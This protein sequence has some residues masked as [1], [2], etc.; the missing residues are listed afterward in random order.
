MVKGM[1]SLGIISFACIFLTI[2]TSY[3]H[4]SS[5]RL[6][7]GSRLT[8]G[9]IGLSVDM[10]PVFS[11]FAPLALEAWRR[12][13]IEPVF[14]LIGNRTS[15]SASTQSQVVIDY[16]RQHQAHIAHVNPAT[17]SRPLSSAF[18]STVGRLFVPNLLALDDVLMM[19]DIDVL[20]LK[21][22]YFKSVVKTLGTN[23]KMKMY[24]DKPVD[25][26][27]PRFSMCYIAGQ[28]RNWLELVPQANDVH[29]FLEVILSPALIHDI[30]L[31]NQEPNLAPSMNF[32]EQYLGYRIKN[33]DCYPDCTSVGDKS[34]ARDYKTL[35][36]GPPGPDYTWGKTLQ[37][38]GKEMLEYLS[39]QIEG[40][41]GEGS[42]SL[43]E[44]AKNP[45]GTLFS[46]IRLYWESEP[47]NRVMDYSKTFFMQRN[48]VSL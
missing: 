1:P 6:R 13:D 33:L 18:L 15:W 47:L 9:F 21:C 30:Y 4:D 7:S 2:Q 37:S 8:K 48:E 20:P 5:P 46:M 27:A 28:V 22:D 16:L 43:Y 14:V 23:T 31:S 25:L 10:S 19:G 40:H 45:N 39:H 44:D 35:V 24:M 41:V 29:H 11:Y 26:Q 38:S 12:C 36:R 3:L 34:F 17:L 42:F 32:D